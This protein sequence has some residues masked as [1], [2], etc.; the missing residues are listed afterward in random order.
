MSFEDDMIEDGFNNESDYLDFLC[1]E[2]D[3]KYFLDIMT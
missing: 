2:A 3:N 1:Y